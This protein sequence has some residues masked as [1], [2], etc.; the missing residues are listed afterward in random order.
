MSKDLG[1]QNVAQ[2]CNLYRSQQFLRAQNAHH[3]EACRQRIYDELAKE[4]SKKSK[5][6]RAEGRL[7]PR[8]HEPNPNFNSKSTDHLAT[9]LLSDG[10]FTPLPDESDLQQPGSYSSSTSPGGFEEPAEF[11]GVVDDNTLL[12]D[13]IAH[14]PGNDVDSI[15]GNQDH[16]DLADCLQSMGINAISATR[17]VQKLHHKPSRTFMEFYGAGGLCKTAQRRRS[18]NIDGLRALDLRTHKPDGTAWDFRRREDR[19]L[20]IHLVKTLKPL[21]VIG[22]PPCTAF[23][24]WNTHLNFANMQAHKSD[25]IIQEGILHLRFVISIYKLHYDSKRCFL[26]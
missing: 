7:S 20:A 16:I 24:N 13:L 5:V 22:S 23:S 26:H 19:D 2:K 6:G 10:K 18:L 1:T 14:D 21:V 17:F 12:K 9:R 4:D 8:S 25:E 3:S 15:F 11:Y